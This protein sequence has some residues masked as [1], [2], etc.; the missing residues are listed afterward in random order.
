M[1]TGRCNWILDRLGSGI[2]VIWIAVWPHSPIKSPVIY[3][4]T[5][6]DRESLSDGSSKRTRR[7]AANDRHYRLVEIAAQ[8]GTTYPDHAT[9]RLGILL[10]NEAAPGETFHVCN[11]G[12]M[13]YKARLDQNFFDVWGLADSF[14][15]RL[16]AMKWRPGHL[17]RDRPLGL[18]ESLASGSPA[19]VDPG[20]SRYFEILRNVT[21]NERLL[22]ANRIKELMGI[23]LGLY[24]ELLPETIRFRESGE[25]V[26]DAE[27]SPLLQQVLK[28]LPNRGDDFEPPLCDLI[29]HP[30]TDALLRRHIP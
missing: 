13:P 19:F 28:D 22:S 5:V 20:L 30:G 3:G 7:M 27:S 9:T 17:V 16:P 10:N 11:L 15:A 1:D 4:E 26:P 2:G 8:N 12:L 24:D 25:I 21:G 6:F 18:A 23:N 14:M 29:H